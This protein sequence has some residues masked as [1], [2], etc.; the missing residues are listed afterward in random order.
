MEFGIALYLARL[1]NLAV[2]GFVPDQALAYQERHER[3]WQSYLPKSQVWSRHRI[4]KLE[5]VIDQK[6][7][8]DHLHDHGHVK[9]RGAIR[10][11]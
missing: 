8:Q 7:R 2:T 10:D 5:L 9:A 1:D 6:V 3:T 11:T 4:G